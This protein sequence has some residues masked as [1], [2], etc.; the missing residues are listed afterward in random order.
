[1]LEADLIKIYPRLYHMA[2]DGSWPSIHKQGLLSATALLDL[3]GVEGAARIAIES[4]HRP[5]SV[6]IS[7]TGLPNAII[8][9]N[10]PMSDG[11]LRKCLRD[12]LT[13]EDWYEILNQKTFFWLSKERLWRLLH[14]RA[15]RRFPQTILTVET[16][17]MIAAHR[18]KILLSPMNSGSTIYSPLPCGLQTFQTVADY[19]FAE[20]RKGRTIHNALVELVVTYG[21]PDIADHVIA[22]HSVQNSK[23]TELW[24]RPGSDTNDGPAR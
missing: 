12:N 21:V 7:K 13:P 14:G 19:P 4:R 24:R 16:S 23:L 17:T 3:Y 18:D 10:K 15:Y 11:A 22:V 1:M 20:R 6:L 9:D 8:R 5:N 2:E